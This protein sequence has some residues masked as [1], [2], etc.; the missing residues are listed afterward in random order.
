MKLIPQIVRENQ[1]S[2]LCEGTI[3][4]F[5]RWSAPYVGNRTPVVMKCSVHGEWTMY[6]PDLFRNVRCAECKGVKNLTE[7]EVL[8]RINAACSGKNFRFTKWET[9]YKN[10]R[11]RAIFECLEHGQWVTG[12]Q[13][14]TKSGSGCPGCSKNGFDVNSAGFLYCFLSEDGEFFKI[15]ITNNLERR[16]V[17]LKRTTPFC[18][19]LIHSIRNESGLLIRSLEKSFHSYFESANLTGFNGA[20]EWLKWN[21]EIPLWFE[22]LNS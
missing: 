13:N 10:A 18:F 5:V 7:K 6:L 12:Y 20:T 9:S 14:V 22:Y 1:I 8:F 15:G 19:E 21:Q 17:E 2:E 16:I 3:Y 4:S 11:S